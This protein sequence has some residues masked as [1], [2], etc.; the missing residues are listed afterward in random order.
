MR[1]SDLLASRMMG[2]SALRVN[3]DLYHLIHS[4]NEIAGVAQTPPDIFEEFRTLGGLV[5]NF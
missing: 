5:V 2:D 3:Q 1:F 4:K